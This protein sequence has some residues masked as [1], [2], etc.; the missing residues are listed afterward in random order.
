MYKEV[1]KGE[2]T[3]RALNLSRSQGCHIGDLVNKAREPTI[4]CWIAQLRKYD[5]ESVDR[6]ESII[7][8]SGFC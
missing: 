5:E 6:R 7:Q 2:D 1:K 3:G 4:K 8:N